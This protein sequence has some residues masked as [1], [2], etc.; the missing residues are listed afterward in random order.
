MSNKVFTLESLILFLIV[1]QKISRKYHL[2][3]KFKKTKLKTKVS[4]ESLE[5]SIP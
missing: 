1:F 2:F 5:K 3:K 4:S